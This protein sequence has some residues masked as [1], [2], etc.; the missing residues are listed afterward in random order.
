MKYRKLALAI[1]VVILC[2]VTLTAYGESNNSMLPV[3]Q[4]DNGYWVNAY[5]DYLDYN[6]G[7]A[8]IASAELLDVD[9]DGQPELVIIDEWGRWDCNGRIVKITESETIVYEDVS[10]FGASITLSLCLDADGN[11]CWYEKEFSAGTGLQVE[12]IRKVEFTES[13]EPIR[14][15]WLTY[16]SEQMDDP[17]TGFA[18]VPT[19]YYVY[20]ESV[21]Y[22]TYRREDLKRRQL[23]P[24]YTAEICSHSYP[25]AWEK[26]VENAAVL[27]PVR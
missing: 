18:I 19:G 24:I 6:Y 20:G 13:M 23:V 5:K 11:A 15:D 4:L 17:E 12:T 7:D 27:N 9:L 10:L 26:M 3:A 14:V 25:E 2:S 22:E 16:T 1:A 21:D 8:Y